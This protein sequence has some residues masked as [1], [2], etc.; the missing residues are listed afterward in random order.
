MEESFPDEG[1]KFIPISDRS[2]EIFIRSK[3]TWKLLR[4][5]KSRIKF[6]ANTALNMCLQDTYI[7]VVDAQLS[8]SNPN[9]VIVEQIQRKLRQKFELLTTPAFVLI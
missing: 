3:A 9:P 5:L 4:Y 1:A 8:F 7:A 2:I 6:N